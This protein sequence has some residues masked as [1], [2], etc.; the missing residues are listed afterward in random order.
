MAV[1]KPVLWIA[2][3]EQKLLECI[4]LFGNKSFWSFIV[5]QTIL[6]WEHCCC[7]VEVCVMLCFSLHKVR[8]VNHWV[9]RHIL[10]SGDLKQRFPTTGTGPSTGTW[11]R[12]KW[13]QK[14][15]QSGIFHSALIS[16]GTNIVYKTGCRDL[17]VGPKRL[18]TTDL[19]STPFTL[20]WF[21]H[22]KSYCLLN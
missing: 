10:Y 8:Q 2:Y 3:G 17:G 12:S 19:K 22:F 20:P 11:R 14:S 21:S 18:G 6:S 5:E 16:H 15:C 7:S 4:A 9:T 1:I 13:D